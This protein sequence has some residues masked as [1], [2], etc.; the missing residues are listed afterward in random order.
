MQHFYLLAYKLLLTISNIL[1]VGNRHDEHPGIIQGYSRAVRFST[2][3]ISGEVTIVQRFS[4]QTLKIS[5]SR[6]EL[7][8]LARSWL[9]ITRA[10]I[11]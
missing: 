1:P 11:Q 3:P 9:H 7:S 5:P 2:P 6:D 8:A 4:Q 10:L